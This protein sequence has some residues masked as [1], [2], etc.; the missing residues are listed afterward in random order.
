MLSYN[1][2]I[3][4]TRLLVWGDG[5]GLTTTVT[6]LALSADHTVYGRIPAQQNVTAGSYAD[7]IV[8]TVTF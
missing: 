3:D 6:N 4:P 1:L 5:S 8:V 7:L 2:Y